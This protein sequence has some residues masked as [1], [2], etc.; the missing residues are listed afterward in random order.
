MLPKV[1]IMKISLISGKLYKEGEAKG[2][3]PNMRSAEIPGTV[4]GN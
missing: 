1:E 3:F 2:A 4:Y